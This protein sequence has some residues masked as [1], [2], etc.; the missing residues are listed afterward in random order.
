MADNGCFSTCRWRVCRSSSH[1]SVRTSSQLSSVVLVV[2]VPVVGL[3]VGVGSGGVFGLAANIMT[4]RFLSDIDTQS[5]TQLSWDTNIETKLEL[6]VPLTR[7][8]L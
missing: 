7:S 2:N 5:I 6:L 8:P 3:L 4:M 1:S